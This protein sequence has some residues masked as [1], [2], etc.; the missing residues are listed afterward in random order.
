M[1]LLIEC[2]QSMSLQAELVM[3]DDDAVCISTCNYM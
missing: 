2:G 1:D 3:E